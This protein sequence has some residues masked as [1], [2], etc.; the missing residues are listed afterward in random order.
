[1]AVCEWCGKEFDLQE[2]EYEFESE[3]FMLSYDNLHKS[4]CGS[5]AVKAIE[6]EVDGVY[7]EICEECGKEF[8]MIEDS[9]KF[10]SHFTGYSGTELRDYW[11]DKILCCDCALEVTDKM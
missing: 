5:C 11:K 2:A 6:D 7:Y 8:D 9:C 3:T 4:L 1:M 10:D